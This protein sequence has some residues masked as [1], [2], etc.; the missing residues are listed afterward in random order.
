MIPLDP[1]GLLLAL[2]QHKQYAERVRRAQ[3][4]RNP[5][6]LAS[7]LLV[8]GQQQQE[9]GEA[10]TGLAA[11]LQSPLSSPGGRIVGFGEQRV[12]YQASSEGRAVETAPPSISSTVDEGSGTPPVF[13][14]GGSFGDEPDR[15]P[16]PSSKGIL[17]PGISSLLSD[18]KRLVSELL[19]ATNYSR[20]SYGYALAA[21]HMASLTR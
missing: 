13:A 2:R 5:R 16:Q 18:P 10:A 12:E 17:V 19:D 20:A 3:L 15:L 9:E 8:S 11:L 6:P 4:A 14:A 7:A 1:V 21:G